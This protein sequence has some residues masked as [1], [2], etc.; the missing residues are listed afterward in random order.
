MKALALAALG[1][2][3]HLAVR[4]I[5]APEVERPGDVRVRVHAAALNRLDL[6]VADGLPGVSYTFPHIVGSD[7]AGIVE[8]VGSAVTRVRVGDRVMINPGLWCGR[9]PACL[10]GEESLCTSFRVI[11]E[12]CP[13]TAAEY[14]V[15]PEENLAPVPPAMPWSEAAAFSLGTLTAWRMLTNRARLLPGETVLIWGIGGGVAMAALGIT[16]HLGGR[17]VVT[18]GAD[19]KL[20]VARRHGADATVNH[21]TADVVAEVRRLTDGR[22]ADVVVD[23]VGQARWQESLRALRRGGRLV[24]CGATSGP[25]ISLDLRRLFWHQW[26]L[27]G[28]TL[29]SRR[30]YDEIVALAHQGH[31][32]PVVDRTVPLD[33]G[34]AAFARLERGEQIGKLVIEVVT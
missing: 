31:L 20:E 32:W 16:R 26:S 4:E 14:V 33:E 13:G 30:E 3:E 23:S 6:F 11:G 12:H 18:S 24:T 1:G 10:A 25:M 8:S 22:G 5:P 17:T 19:L 9:C 29:G 27:L 2:L 34:L 21:A 15:V 28:S 7:G